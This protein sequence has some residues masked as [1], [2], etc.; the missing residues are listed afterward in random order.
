MPDNFRSI[1]DV[2]HKEKE[3]SKIIA[4]AKEE[5]IVQKFSEIFPEL[6]EIA[7]A[8]K[9]NRNIL[10]LRVENSVW[11]SELNLKQQAMIS[12]I[13]KQFS[14]IQIDRIKFIS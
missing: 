6:N 11:K 7:K 14:N 3:F 4:K 1:S 8:V 9:F 12:K 13:K 2:L 10:F 5:E